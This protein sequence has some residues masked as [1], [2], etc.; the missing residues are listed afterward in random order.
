[1]AAVWA[2]SRMRELYPRLFEAAFLEHRVP[3]P[4]HLSTAAYL[5]LARR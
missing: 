2:A 1:L 4:R 3:N 5:T